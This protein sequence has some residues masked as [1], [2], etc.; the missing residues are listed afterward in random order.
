MLLCWPSGSMLAS[1]TIPEA[2]CVTIAPCI[3]IIKHE[4]QRDK[5]FHFIWS[6]SGNLLNLILIGKPEV[7]ISDELRAAAWPSSHRRL[8]RAT[9]HAVL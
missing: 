6:L 1:L 7:R 2:P 3:N 9:T 5:D 4:R 8:G